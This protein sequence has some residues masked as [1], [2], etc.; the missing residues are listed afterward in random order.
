MKW[1]KTTS[2]SQ[3][4]DSFFEEQQSFLVANYPGIT[5][6][7]IKRQLV[8]SS[9]NESIGD[10]SWLSY[11]YFRRADSP[12]DKFF[13]QLKV[14]KPLA[15]LFEHSWFYRSEFYITPNVLIPRSETEILVERAVH[16]LKAQKKFHPSFSARILEVGVG[17]GALL[18]SIIRDYHHNL[19]A[20]GID[21]DPKALSISRINA[22][23][24]AFSFNSNIPLQ[25]MLGDR[26]STVSEN[27][28]LIVSNPPYIKEN[29]DLSTVHVQVD[30]F[31]P[32]VALYLPD[33]E[34][35][36]W[37][38]VFFD[39]CFAHLVSGGQ[40]MMEGH[41]DHLSDLKLLAEKCGFD[42]VTIICDYTG[43]SR[44]LVAARP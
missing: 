23:R 34:Y 21:I 1:R 13:E 28:D 11:A 4:I 33:A 29:A 35:Q 6:A 12:I 27:F 44:F 15:H 22:F 18:L 31:E 36:N 40:L 9:L 8:H 10:E 5:P 43:R 16:W 19:R 24:L 20:M 32:K 3:Y 30:R 14:G 26:L 41:E 7:I 38:S 39:Q 17:S 42:R 25:W 37:F 2:L